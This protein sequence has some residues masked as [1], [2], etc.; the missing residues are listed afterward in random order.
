MPRAPQPA[1]AVRRWFGR[2]LEKRA[3][4]LRLARVGVRPA[5]FEAVAVAAP[6]AALLIGW[7]YSPVVGVA[8]LVA[9]VLLPRLLLSFLTA[10]RRGRS[11]KQAPQLLQLLL[12]NL[13]AG[14]TYLEALQAARR[15]ITDRRLAE[16]LTDVVQQFLLDVPLEAALREIRPR[17]VGRNLGLVWDNLTICAAQKIPAERARE[18]SS[19]SP[20]RCASTCS[21]PGRFAPRPPASASRS[22]AGPAGTGHLPLSAAGQP[23]LPQRPRRHLDRALRLAANRRGVP[24]GPRDLPELPALPGAGLTCRG[25]CSSPPRSSAC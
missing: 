1:G 10:R 23:L 7:L 2:R 14:S 3:A 15:N 21:W 9:G 4:D 19:T 5:L 24:G 22:G 25:R 20:P 11:E 8:G 17:I 12:A 13:G 16:D 6:P 18:L